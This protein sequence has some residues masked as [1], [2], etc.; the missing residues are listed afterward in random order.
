L[1]RVAVWT[2]AALAVL[3]APAA[4]RAQEWK[5]FASRA[6]RFTCNFPGTPTVSATTWTSEYGAELHGRVYSAASGPGRYSITAIDYGPVERILTE[7]SQACPAGAETC[8][9][10]SDTGAGYWKNDVRGAVVYAA[11][12]LMRRPGVQTTHLHWNFMDMV[13]GQ[14][15]QLVDPD[16]SRTFASVYFHDH[17]LIIME[18]TVPAGY[19]E[20]G[21]FQ[22]SLGW[23]DETG[24]GIRYA[25]VY[26][27]DPDLPTPPLSPRSFISDYGRID[28]TGV[29]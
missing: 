13:A 21:L 10:G 1:T 14:Q 9:G 24:R 27:G 16:G 23:L 3:V 17:R 2:I 25:W 15:L 7:K 6:D 26:Y 28:A 18:G 4:A 11:W 20:P 19:P 22:Q 29:R 8:R 5:E 12:K